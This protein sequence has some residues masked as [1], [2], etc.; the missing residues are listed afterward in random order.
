VQAGEI[1]FRQQRRA[2]DLG[3][4]V[5][6]HDTSNRRRDVEIGGLR[7]LDHVGQLA[8]AKAAPPVEDRRRR[9]T[10]PRAV[11]GRDVGGEIR[12]LGA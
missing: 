9:L 1:D 6:L 10:I 3:L 5:G 7:L 4:S 2:D 8:R 11:F 12:P